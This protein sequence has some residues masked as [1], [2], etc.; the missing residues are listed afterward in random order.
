MGSNKKRAKYTQC[1]VSMVLSHPHQY[2]FVFAVAA[3]LDEFG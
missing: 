1:A 3:V 2:L